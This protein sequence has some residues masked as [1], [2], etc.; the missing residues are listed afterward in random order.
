MAGRSG[1]YINLTGCGN[2]TLNLSTEIGRKWI[3]D[4]LCYWVEECHVDG[5]RFDLLLVLGR[6]TPDF[7]ANAL[8]FKEIEQVSISQKIKFIAEPWDIGMGGYQVVNFPA[9][10]AEWNDQFRDDMC[11][12]W[13]W[14]SGR[15]R[16]FCRRFA[17]SSDIYRCQGKLPHNSVNFI[18]T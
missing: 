12:F 6:E 18:T 7:N 14:K 1:N 11:R 8:L 3:I 4:C 5:F 15:T 13:L 2:I 10:F 9:Y 17:G 16:C